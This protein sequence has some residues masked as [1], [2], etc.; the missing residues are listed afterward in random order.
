MTCSICLQTTEVKL[1]GLSFVT[2]DRS[3]PLWIGITV[4]LLQSPGRVLGEESMSWRSSLCS[5]L[6]SHV[7]S[8]F[9]GPN[10]LYTLFSNTLSLRSSLNVSD[11]VSH[12]YRTTVQNK[13][14]RAVYIEDNRRRREFLVKGLGVCDCIITF[15]WK[16]LHRIACG[17]ER[18][19]C[20]DCR[21]VSAPRLEGARRSGSIAPRIL[22]F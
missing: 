5:L 21:C 6:H 8:S 20:Q 16:S 22:N 9:L 15:C 10:I 4:A 19:M 17:L 1:T 13:I 12:P 7:T 18:G 14:I 11:H 2:N 3:P